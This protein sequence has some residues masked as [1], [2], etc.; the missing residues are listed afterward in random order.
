MQSLPSHVFNFFPAILSR[1][2]RL[3]SLPIHPSIYFYY[4]TTYPLYKNIPSED[5]KISLKARMRV[6]TFSRQV[7]CSAFLNFSYKY[8][9]M[10]T[11]NAIKYIPKILV[12]TAWYYDGIIKMVDDLLGLFTCLVPYKEK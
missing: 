10:P 3:L 6:D 4:K 5:T 11:T 7:F 1:S 2:T 9:K 8:L 12:F